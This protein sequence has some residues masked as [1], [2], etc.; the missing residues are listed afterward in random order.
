[1]SPRAN[2]RRRRKQP[3]SVD[4]RR[5]VRTLAI[6]GVV[7]MMAGA[8]GWGLL[9]LNRALSVDSW[10]IEAPDSLRAAI[11]TRLQRQPMDFCHTFP[12]LLRHKLMASIPALADVRISRSVGGAL[13]IRAIPRQAV[14]NWLDPHGRMQ[15]VDRHGLAY[16]STGAPLP[17]LP[18]LR[19][20]AGQLPKAA[21]MLSHLKELSHSLFAHLS[22]M[23]AIDGAWK[24]YFDHGESWVIPQHGAIRRVNRL[25]ALIEQPRWRKDAW[26]IDARMDN[27]WFIRPAS[28]KEVI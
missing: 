12:P 22:E 7:A 4:R 28:S 27:R 6:G 3:R 15:L 14:A 21:A 9:Y 24:L 17:I 2:T 20:P 10:R 26:R 8:G 5:L 13:T 25:V 19:L 23:D 16:A 11:A 18:M 1:M